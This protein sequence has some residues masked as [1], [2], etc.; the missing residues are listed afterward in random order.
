MVPLQS[1]INRPPQTIWVFAYS[2][3]GIS[4]HWHQ[5][6][7]YRFLVGG[8]YLLDDFARFRRK[9]DEAEEEIKIT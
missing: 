6:E 9:M 8:C 3:A 1:S 5:H 2:W 7:N 4:D